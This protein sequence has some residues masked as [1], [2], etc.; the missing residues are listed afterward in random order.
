MQGIETAWKEAWQ[1]LRQFADVPLPRWLP[2]R[3]KYPMPCLE[4]VTEGLAQELSQPALS[5]RIR[6][7]MSVAIAVG[8]RGVANI[9]EI[10]AHVAHHL[11]GQ[12]AHPFVV[13]AM[14]SHGAS[15]AEG[16]AEYLRGL[17]VSEERTG[18]PIRATMDVVDLGTTDDGAKVYFDRYAHAADAVVP[19]CRIK[20]HTS[21][22]GT[23]ESGAVKMLA[24]GMGKQKGAESLHAKG[25]AHMAPR[26]QSAARLILAKQNVPF[27]V[28]TV[29]NARDQT[30]HVEAVPGEAILEREPRLL[31]LAW[32][33]MGRLLIEEID[34][35]VVG[36]IGKNISG[37]GMDPN[38]VG[39]FSV[40]G[41][42]GKTRVNKLVV[43][44]LTEESHGNALGIG[45]AD[46]LSARV[47]ESTDLT[48]LYVN[49]LTSTVFNGA[50]IPMCAPTDEVALRLAVRTCNRT[51]AS[52]VRL[53]YIDST[54][55]LERIHVSEAI[56]GEI[57]SNQSFEALG[58]LGQI[59][60]DATGLL[61]PKSFS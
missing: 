20:P 54:K 55:S 61:T 52:Q 56:W 4:S 9:G 6:P 39:R 60:F 46:I 15:T 28:C 29:E 21:F 36:A 38:V 35:L 27:A 14:G 34:V 59:P 10:V 2:V 58:E 22:R 31:E 13:P 53:V 12:G 33:Y 32:E 26:L 43:L 18:C 5:G 16:Q 47:L 42:T 3:Q 30:A 8:S 57:R 19:V 48:A 1:T 50:K 41:M 17:G 25:F 45:L 51:P 37:M 24:I 40:E 7:G 11:R 49:I 44:G 23:T